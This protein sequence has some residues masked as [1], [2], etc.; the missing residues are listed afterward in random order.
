MAASN[1]SA[2]SS[3]AILKVSDR[4]RFSIEERIRS[5][6][7]LPGDPV[8]EPQLMN[9]FGVSR[10]PVR[11]ALLQLQAQGLLVSLGKG[12]VV[13][14]KMD[15]QQLLA[16]W[17]LL[18]DLESLCARYACQR[19]TLVERDELRRVHESSAL[20][21]SADDAEA[22]QE[23]NSVFHEVL[24]RGARNPYL[25]QE[26]LRMRARTAAYRRHAFR[27]VGSLQT[28]FEHHGRIV[29]AIL[30]HDHATAAIAGHGHMSPG[31]GAHGVTALIMN[32]PRELL[33]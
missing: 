31:E 4:I 23:T 1:H 24:Y 29:A 16:V 19:M 13:V 20:T 27:A 17:E 8:D 25:R 6:D 18:A 11:E 10:T 32:L 22:W 3:R 30:A 15:V 5:G 21:V 14:A 28:S 2:G 9:D 12:G 7:L 33:S 26:I